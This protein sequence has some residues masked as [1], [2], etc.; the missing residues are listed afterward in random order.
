[1]TEGREK[2]QDEAL[3]QRFRAGDVGAMEALMVRYKPLVRQRAGLR[4]LS[5]GDADDL[6]QEGM[7]G[8]YRAAQDFDA[9]KAGEGSFRSFAR[10]CIDRQILKAIDRTKTGG[11]LAMTSSVP[12]DESEWEQHLLQTDSAERSPEHIFLD[13]EKRDELLSRILESLSAAERKVLELRLA[14]YGYRDIAE[15]L[16]ISEKSVDNTIQRI[17]KKSRRVL[18]G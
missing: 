14:G 1:M 2:L 6:I 4:F 3:I 17:R 16:R 8:L 5:G 11:N 12:L 18:A 15:S 10:L 9:G 13:M 7:I